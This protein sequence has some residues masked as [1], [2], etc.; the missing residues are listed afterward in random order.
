[1]KNPNKKIQNQ[2]PEPPPNELNAQFYSI[3]GNLNTITSQIN[4][5]QLL[6]SIP[7]QT[8]IPG[9]MNSNPSSIP[10]IPSAPSI[11][12]AQYQHSFNSVS[13]A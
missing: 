5:I 6:S 12:L 2:Q 7:L 10:G 3:P 11:P 1:M 13:T 8:I 9:M 4:N